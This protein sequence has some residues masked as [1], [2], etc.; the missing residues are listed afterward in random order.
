MVE[1]LAALVEYK[2]G[3]ALYAKVELYEV[4]SYFSFIVRG[5]A[6]VVL[7]AQHYKIILNLNFLMRTHSG[8][9]FMPIAKMRHSFI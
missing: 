4:Y 7:K 6:T 5:F 8:I 2:L 3:T 1:R 9:F